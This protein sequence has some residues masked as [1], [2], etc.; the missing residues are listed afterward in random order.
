MKKKILLSSA[1]SSVLATVIAISATLNVDNAKT[2]VLSTK[3]Y[4]VSGTLGLLGIALFFVGL[5][6]P[7]E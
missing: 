1:L 5:V 2:L 7:K 4:S 3:W 6:F